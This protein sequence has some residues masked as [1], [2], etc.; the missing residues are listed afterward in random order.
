MTDNTKLNIDLSV[1][2][3]YTK[4]VN[5]KPMTEDEIK[6]A[7]NIPPHDEKN[8]PIPS[9]E[10]QERAGGFMLKLLIL[11]S[12]VDKNLQSLV[13]NMYIDMQNFFMD[14][15]DDNEK[16]MKLALTLEKLKSYLNITDNPIFKEN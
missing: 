9:K 15:S 16:A 3:T 2:N 7:L 12:S 6:A 8:F 5:E 4:P 11:A 10:E 1:A 13:W 14:K